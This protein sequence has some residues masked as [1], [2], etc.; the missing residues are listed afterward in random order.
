MSNSR[1][2][3]TG[4]ASRPEASHACHP[5]SYACHP[6]N[7]RG[8][9]HAE[10]PSSLRS[11]F[12]R[13]R[14]RIVHSTAFRRLEYKTQVFVNHEGD[15]FRT[16]LTH[17]LEVA[18]IARTAAR[19][20]RLDEDLAEAVALAHDLGHSPFGH[21]GELALDA[22]LAEFGGFDHNAQ[23]LRVVTHLER[24]YAGFDG[25][26]LSWETLEGVVKHNGPLIGDRAPP[27]VAAYSA[28]H[29][30]ALES[31]PSAE[32]QIAALADDIAYVNHDL[33]DGLRAR[34]FLLDDLR[35]LPLVGPS[36]RAVVGLYPDVEAPRLVHETLRRVI[37]AMVADLVEET[38]RKLAEL[39]PA[40][41][42][43]IRACEAPVVAF[44]ATI[45][46]AIAQLRHFLHAHM[47]SHYKVRRM[48]LKAQ[49]IVEELFDGLLREPDC[50]PPA[51]R[52]RAGAPGAPR[53]VEAIADYI[54]GM[55]DRYALDEHDRLF[56]L[57]ARY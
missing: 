32:A 11:P 6:R 22:V 15:H 12:Q 49:R 53:T 35:E 37:D 43:D 19:A 52:A 44:S 29:D 21:A 56:N 48:S 55:T 20:L 8:R 14:D 42:D 10:D 5:A 17:T 51:W 38:E 40:S 26:N 50:L 46:D 25:L 16:R 31:H 18:Q 28:D 45:A 2:G 30:L 23:T 13:D 3:S 1:L 41:V 36:I 33:D 39:A 24:R 54:A 34:M 7:S 27:Y 57:T 4:R 47:Y 9:R